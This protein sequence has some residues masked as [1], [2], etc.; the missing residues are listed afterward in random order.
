[1][2]VGPVPRLPGKLQVKIYQGQDDSAKPKSIGSISDPG[3]NCTAVSFK[4]QPKG[5]FQIQR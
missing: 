1:M 4:K 2:F 5:A 3:T